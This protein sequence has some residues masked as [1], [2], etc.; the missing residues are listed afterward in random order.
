MSDVRLTISGRRLGHIHD[1]MRAGECAQDCNQLEHSRA[2]DMLV[3]EF[4]L[5]PS[6][7]DSLGGGVRMDY[8]EEIHLASGILWRMWQGSG[9][10]VRGIRCEVR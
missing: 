10:G 8:A 6:D 7:I 9:V 2:V 1:Q 4:F 5:C 3:C